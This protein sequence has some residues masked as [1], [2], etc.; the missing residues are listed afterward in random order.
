LTQPRDT[1]VETTL[2]SERYLHSKL[3][4]QTFVTKMYHKS[5]DNGFENVF[6]VNDMYLS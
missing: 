5:I 4:W 3:I 1:S 2:H 6:F